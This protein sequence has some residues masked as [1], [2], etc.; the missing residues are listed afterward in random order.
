MVAGLE[1]RVRSIARGCVEQVAPG[2]AV[3]LVELV[4]AP[5]PLTVIADLLGVP[6]ADRG[7]FKRWSDLAFDVDVRPGDPGWDE[8]V[9]AFVEMGAY[10]AQH[11][12]QRRREPRDDLISVL[13]AAELDGER[14]DFGT[15]FE[16]CRTILAAGND[17]TRCL[18]SG[19]VLALGE[20]PEQLAALRADTA[21]IPNAVEEMLRY[22]TPIHTF[23]RTTTAATELRG[24]AIGAGERVLLLYASANR[25]E[26]VWP[27]PEAFDAGRAFGSE[28]LAF[29]WGPH[30][31]LGASLARLEVRVLLEEL[32]DR[33]EGWEPAGAAERYASTLA[34]NYR[35]VPL[36][37]QAAGRPGRAGR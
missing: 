26:D 20:H 9:T 4:S 32:V 29:G 25:D 33:F 19:G 1:E 2:E 15:V 22:V 28:Q 37:F 10:F 11:V 13:L 5:L 24:Q 16:F 7:D 12:E 27:D 3:D 31:C 6:A 8:F 30:H 23:I 21:A 35:R 17:T 14:L 18:I 34:S 36:V